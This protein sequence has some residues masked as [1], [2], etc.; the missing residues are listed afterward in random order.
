MIAVV[1]ATYVRSHLRA[2]LEDLAR[3]SEL[4]HVI[5]V[6]NSGETDEIERPSTLGATVL[7]PGAN[8][9]WLRGTNLGWSHALTLDAVE[10]FLLLNDDTRLSKGFVAG[11]EAAANAQHD[12]AVVGPVYDDVWPQ[13]RVPYVGPAVLYEP[14]NRERPVK[15]VDGTAMYVTRQAAETI[16]L[17]DESHFGQTGW[18]ADLDYCLAAADAGM[19]V[20]VTQRSY[21][22]H[23]GGSTAVRVLG[24]YDDMAAMEM[25]RGMTDKHGT[26]WRHLLGIAG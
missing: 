7:K 4:V 12:V 3:E 8:L 10:G 2:L 20:I 1:V 5:L 23:Y 9:G 15:F 16:G 6:D 26:G 14:V 21:L 17:L 24:A 19:S 18:G 22:N 13:Q 25:E 11:L